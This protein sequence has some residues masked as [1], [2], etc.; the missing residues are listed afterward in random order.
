MPEICLGTRNNAKITNNRQKIKRQ[1]LLYWLKGRKRIP[2][3]NVKK[4]KKNA[5]H[6]KRAKNCIKIY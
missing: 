1:Y 5:E 6:E 3:T 4:R 2:F